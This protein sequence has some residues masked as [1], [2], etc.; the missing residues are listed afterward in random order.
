[1]GLKDER[2]CALDVSTHATKADTTNEALELLDAEF[3]SFFDEGLDAFLVSL[4]ILFEDLAS[5]HFL[6]EEGAA[7]RINFEFGLEIF[8]SAS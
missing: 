6:R 1:M 5:W 8:D 4:A 3:S 2:E 7:T